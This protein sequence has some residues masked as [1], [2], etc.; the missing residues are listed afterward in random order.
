MQ[1]HHPYNIPKRSIKTFNQVPEYIAESVL[2]KKCF[3]SN[4]KKYLIEHAFYSFEE[5]VWTL[6]IPCDMRTNGVY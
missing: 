5:Y 4:L 1:K 3:L 2:K 6:I